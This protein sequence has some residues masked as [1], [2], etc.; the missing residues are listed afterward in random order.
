MCTRAKVH[1]NVSEQGDGEAEQQAVCLSTGLN[2]T[3][4]PLYGVCLG[5]S[6]DAVASN[7]AHCMFDEYEANGLF[8]VCSVIHQTHN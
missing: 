6:T 1:A 5:E 8:S 4:Q 7:A 3:D 2:N